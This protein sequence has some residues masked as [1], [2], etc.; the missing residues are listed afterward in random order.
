MVGR[1]I[2]H[3]LI[4]G[5]MGLSLIVAP[6]AGEARSLFH[7]TSRAVA[8]KIMQKGFSI[9]T[10]N[11]K[12]RFGKGAY[13]SKSKKA[14]LHER[15]RAD[16]VVTFNE[17]KLLEKSTVNT[18]ALSRNELKQFSHDRDLRGNIH[19]GIP[20]GDLAHKMGG[21]AGRKSKVLMYPSA[22][23]KGTN[24]FIPRRVYSEHPRIVRPDSIHFTASNR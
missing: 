24:V 3:K 16:A 2:L 12:A 22:R 11:P 4:A 17:S 14:A 9:R 18:K 21:Q 5:S 10:M 1:A 20:G 23:G 13:L 7:A 6:L 8:K 19:K 15:P